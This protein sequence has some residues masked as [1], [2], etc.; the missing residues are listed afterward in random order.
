M[1]D[2]SKF[3]APQRKRISLL[4]CDELVEVKKD[5]EEDAS[6]AGVAKKVSQLDLSLHCRL[7][8]V[9]HLAKDVGK[10]D[11]CT[12]GVTITAAKELIECA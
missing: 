1:P 11:A 10:R 8:E 5:L 12:R 3:Y 9:C 2:P 7:H 4:E 6:V